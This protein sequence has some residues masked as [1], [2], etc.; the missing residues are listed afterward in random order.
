M[1]QYGIIYREMGKS[2]KIC[3]VIGTLTYSGAEKIMYNLLKEFDKRGHDL[4]LILIS[5]Q[6]KY[7]YPDL[8]NITQYPIFNKDEIS[9]KTYKRVKIRQNKIK[10]IIANNCF[11]LVV[12]FGSKFNIDVSEACR[13]IKTK[14]IL[15]ER[16]DPINDPKSKLLRIRRS[17][18]YKW[19]DGFVFQTEEIKNF[20]SSSIQNR[21]TVIPNFIDEKISE[22]YLNI[23][24]RKSFVT[25]ARLDDNQKNQTGVIKA[26]SEFCKQNTDYFLEFYGDGPDLDKYRELVHVLKIENRVIFHGYISNPMKEAVHCR[27]FVFT[28]KYEGMPN[29]LI[30][31]MSYGMTCIATDCSGGGAKYLINNEYNGILVNYGDEVELLSVMNRV[32]K[33]ETFSTKLGKNAFEIND[34]LEKNKIIDMWEN[35]FLKIYQN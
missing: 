11:D 17:I 26:F 7:D 9:L 20:F 27:F 10:T 31:A 19:A 21:S 12:S 22:T 23:R 15:C 6:E 25:C 32:A 33:D 28:S 4:S 34:R 13:S 29:A 8:K 2:M 14:L 24:K 30:E 35:Y 3:F 18:S 1:C 16:N 5:C